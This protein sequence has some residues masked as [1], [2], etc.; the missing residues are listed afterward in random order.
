MKFM[1]KA[2]EDKK[3]AFV[4]DVARLIVVY[5]YG[6]L[7]FDTDVEVICDYKDILTENI[8]GF[9]GIEGLGTVATGLGFC[10]M[11]KHPF[12]AELIK[13]YENI[14]YLQ[15]KDC[16]E[17]IACPILTTEIMNKKGFYITDGIQEYCGLKIYPPEYF[18]PFD[19]MTGNLKITTRTHSIH[20]YNA[21]WNQKE[22]KKELDIARKYRNIFGTKTGEMIYGVVTC[23]KREGCVKYLIARLRR[24]M[25]RK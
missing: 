12:I 5:Q 1:Q 2:Y 18:S 24:I 3:W 7:Y 25:S 23:I 14:D 19:Y 4:S 13:I 8:E 6:G 10:A 20:W 17:K 21:S 16:L 9:M 15:Y 11:P 22:T